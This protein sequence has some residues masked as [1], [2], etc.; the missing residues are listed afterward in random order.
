M[1]RILLV[2]AG[3]LLAAAAAAQTPALRKG[4]SVQMA[5]TTNAVAMPDADQADSVVVAVTSR[6]TVYFDITTV[7]PAQLSGK[8]KAALEGRPGK[9][10]YLKGDA[11][12]PYSTVAEVLD[13]LRT[14]RVDAPILLTDQHE[15]TTASYVLPKGLEVMLT[16]APG[17]AESI[18]LKA[19]NGQASDTE[20]KQR[21]Q[22]DKAVVLRAD[23]T[24]PFGDVVHAVD[25]CRAA[26]AKVF[27]ATPGK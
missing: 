1:S 6:G 27:L 16:P 19:G 2:G 13:A 26:G 20:L 21:A 24:E 3:A 8:V 11:R 22:R 9:R 17:A 12:T 25:V 15:P 10:V 7:T 23:G 5:V 4:V 18:T 14:A